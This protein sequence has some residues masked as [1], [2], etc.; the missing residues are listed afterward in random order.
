MPFLL[1]IIVIEEIIP[2]IVMYV[3][4]MLPSTCV[5]PSQRA[6]IVAKRHERQREAYASAKMTNAFK[7]VTFGEVVDKVRVQGK[8][9]RRREF[10]T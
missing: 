1:T 4:G 5:L 6:R 10:A 2:L 3:P 8:E 9:V 7:D